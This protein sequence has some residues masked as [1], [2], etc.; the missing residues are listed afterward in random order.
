MVF[1]GYG[2]APLDQF[3][4]LLVFA[5]VILALAVGDVMISL[6]RLLQAGAKVKWDWLAPMAAAVV[7][8]KIVTQWWGWFGAS[9]V[10]AGITFGMYLGVLAGAVLL[11]LLAATALPDG[12]EETGVD[13]R[14]YYEEVQRRF[15]L[16]FAAHWV[17]ATGVTI[18]I[19]M[20]VEGERFTLHSPAFLIAPVAVV[21]AF[22]WNR[23]VHTAC[24][25]GFFVLYIGDSFAR[26][27]GH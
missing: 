19:E 11:F 27:L 14:K 16:L 26:V 12:I 17:V 4:Y 1:A 22:W 21:L 7:F 20:A 15:W 6:N 9:Q 23:W 13:L 24:L 3:E 18:W 8:L 10:A 25:A 5:S 2:G